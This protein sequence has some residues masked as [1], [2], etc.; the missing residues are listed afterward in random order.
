MKRYS[1][2]IAF[3]AACIMIL[4]NACAVTPTPTATPVPTLIAATLAPSETP[5]PAIPRPV[6]TGAELNQAEL[7]RYDALDIKVTAQ[8]AHANP[9]DARV[10]RLDSIFTAPDGVQTAIPGF[11]NGKDSWHVRFT[12][13]QVGEWHYQLLIKDPG[14]ISVPTQGSFTVTAS[15]L[16]GAIQIG[17]RVDPAYSSHYLAYQ[18]GTPFYGI[19]HADALNI[20]KGG[21]DLDSGFP[22]LYKLQAAHENY[23]VWWPFYN[24]SPISNSYDNYFA[25]KMDIMDLVVRDAQKKNIKLIFTI[26]D[27][28]ELRD[29]THA[30][31]P[32]QWQSNGFSKL[33]DINSFFTS[34]EAWAWQENL[35][36]YIIA[37]W[38]YSTAI[39]MWMTVSEINGTNAY[40]QTNPW[41]E[42]VNAYFQTNDPYHHPTTASMSGDVDWPE[43]HKVM[44]VPQ[45]HVY[46]FKNG[47]AKI[48]D[49]HAAAVLA[50]WTELMWSQSEKPNWVGEF[51]VPG[52][53]DYP[54]LFHNSIWAALASGAA[55]T[56]A[57][58]NG[59]GAWGQ[60]TVEMNADISR[61]AQFVEG[62]PLVKLNPA[63]LKIISSN[64]QV[65]GWGVA[66]ADGGLFWIQDFSLEGKSTDTIRRDKSTRVGQITIT[67]LP[68]G[69]YTITPYDTWKGLYRTTIEVTCQDGK[70]CQI[71]MPKFHADLAFKIEKK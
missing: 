1:T 7:G 53:Q 25:P 45:V 17:S 66:G 10:M 64:D 68:A 11:W 9:Y 21:Y 47:D 37:R 39:G 42:K 61:L 41:H 70:P 29:S 67:G 4:L 62:I 3:L 28:P 49:V 55:M 51:G 13:S 19:G 52:D 35:Y 14:G 48:D 38:G 60:M 33:G 15:D 16:H 65:R 36:R 71:K 20:I 12:P 2:T 40:D 8:T 31:G 44:D 54:E 23:I 6:I 58:W 26:W 5:T 46:D 57:E 30:W 24:T 69:T 34:E 50:H 56:P 32:G 59:D 27:H 63:P 22:T 43:G 18:D